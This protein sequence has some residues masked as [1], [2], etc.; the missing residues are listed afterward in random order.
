MPMSEPRLARRFTNI[1][2]AVQTGF[3]GQVAYQWARQW[4]ANGQ[5]SYTHAQN[6]DWEEPLAE[7][8]PLEGNIG[9]KYQR[10]KWWSDAR[11]RLVAAQNRISSNFGETETPGFAT[12]DLRLGFN[13][14][15]KLSVGFSALNLF[16]VNYYEHL[17]RG[18]RNM[19]E[20]GLL[21]EQGRNFTFFVKYTFLGE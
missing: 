21:Y 18:Y 4:S 19:P 9:L 10:N 2:A 7:I 12:V 17:N 16:D 11:L 20:Q 15:K 14:L 1:A 5:I 8:P 6:L 13:P 3:E